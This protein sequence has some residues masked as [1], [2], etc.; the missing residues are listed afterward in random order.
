MKTNKNRPT[1]LEQAHEMANRPVVDFANFKDLP[2]DMVAWFNGLY[3][4][5]V[6]GEAINGENKPDMTNP[7][8]RKWHPW[9]LHSL[10]PSGFA[11]DDSDCG[12]SS[13]YAGSGSRLQY[14]DSEDSK[15]SAETFIDVWKD[16][17]LG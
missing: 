10:G 2:E 14:N 16:V 6:I 5:A 15:Y 3:R 13:A 1:S 8:T 11:F 17:Q 9:F 12:T 4:A 7:N